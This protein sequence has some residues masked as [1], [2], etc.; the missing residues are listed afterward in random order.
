MALLWEK[1]T[2]KHQKV[3]MLVIFVATVGALYSCS[4][5]HFV[6]EPNILRFASYISIVLT[7]FSFLYV[8]YLFHNNLWIPAPGWHEHSKVKKILLTASI[9]FFMFGLLWINLVTTAPQLFTVFYGI[10]TIKPSL[11]IKDRNY[12]R[13]QCKYIIKLMS[14]HTVHFHYCISEYQYSI[15]PDKEMRADLIVKQSL[16]GYIIEDIKFPEDKSK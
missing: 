4:K 9:P 16:F 10:N 6:V 1:E 3:V 11:V 7:V 14:V 2:T 5:L 13:R 12:S 15:L 8:I